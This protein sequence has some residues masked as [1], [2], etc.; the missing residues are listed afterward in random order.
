LAVELSK[1]DCA[2]Y[3]PVKLSGSS[4]I[5]EQKVWI[6]NKTIKEII[7]FGKDLDEKRYQMTIQS[8]QLI[9]DLKQLPGGDQTELGENGINL[10][11]G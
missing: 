6:E 7:L 11:G 5:A 8:C 2:K 4:A 10:S 1:I 3:G 9:D